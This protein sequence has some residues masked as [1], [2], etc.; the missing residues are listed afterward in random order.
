MIHIDYTKDLSFVQMDK[1]DKGNVT[2]IERE[3]E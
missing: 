1:I 2:Q 3:Q